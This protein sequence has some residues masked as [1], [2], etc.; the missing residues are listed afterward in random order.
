MTMT[1]RRVE[2]TPGTQMPT[3]SRRSLAPRVVAGVVLVVIGALW[4]LERLGAFDLTV[5]TVLAIGTIVV[6]LALMVLATDGPHSGLIVF[7]TILALVTTLTAAAPLEGFQGGVGERV[8][9]IADLADLESEYNLAMGNLTIDLTELAEFEGM[10]TI[11]AS[12][13]MGELVILV[14]EDVAVS[15]EAS[16]GA[17]DLEVFDREANGL[18]VDQAFESERFDEAASGLIIGA[19]VFMGRVEVRNG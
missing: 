5:T 3:T 17:G 6:G 8:V 16:A 18:S 7:G 19:D 12:V 11:D 15:V 13:G 1:D 9:E 2:E 14:P 10:A 4:L